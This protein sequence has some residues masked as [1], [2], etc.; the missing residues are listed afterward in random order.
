MSPQG[1]TS[2]RRSESCRAGVASSVPLPWGGLGPVRH[3]S[4]DRRLAARELDMAETLIARFTASFDHSRYE[5]AYLTRLLKV[6]QQK[7]K[8][9]EVHAAPVEEREAPPDLMEAL[10]AS[11]ASAKKPTASN[12]RGSPKRHAKSAPRKRREERALTSAWSHASP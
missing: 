7:R 11:V 5:D 10:R 2:G 6:V 12:G 3:F 4:R 9:Q 8:G 1:C